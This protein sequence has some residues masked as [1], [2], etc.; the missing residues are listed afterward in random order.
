M[1]AKKTFVSKRTTAP[2]TK[3]RSISNLKPKSDSLSETAKVGSLNKNSPAL[4]RA[5]SANLHTT[6]TRSTGKERVTISQRNSEGGEAFAEES[7]LDKIDG[8][9]NS[10]LT[11]SAIKV[12]LE[13][14]KRR[15]RGD[16]DKQI[17]ALQKRVT[18]S[19]DALE[20]TQSKLNTVCLLQEE[21][22]LLAHH[23]E[24]CNTFSNEPAFTRGK[25]FEELLSEI[26]RIKNQLPCKNVC[27][28]ESSKELAHFQDATSQLLHVMDLI[29]SSYGSDQTPISLT[30]TE[31]DKINTTRETVQN[32]KFSADSIS[33]KTSSSILNEAIIK[34]AEIKVCEAFDAL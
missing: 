17:A 8:A 28:P 27:T 7:K 9:Y 10:Y 18:D 12:L 34:T 2:L 1:E 33:K 13:K 6:S 15:I 24:A 25:S 23:R 5:S 30:A 11:S 21:T 20:Q 29:S 22:N 4:L 19:L 31:L 32:I 26:N 16:I 3:S 14:S